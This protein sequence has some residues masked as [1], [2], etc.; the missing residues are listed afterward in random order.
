MCQKLIEKYSCGDDESSTFPCEDFFT[1]G[2]CDKLEDKVID[3][4]S[5]K[6]RECQHLDD[7]LK[8]IA[9]D[10]SLAPEPKR[11]GAEVIDPNRP[12]KYYKEYIKWNKCGHLSH[13]KWTDIERFDDGPEIGFEIEGYGRCHGCAEADPQTLRRMQKNGELEK[14]DPWGFMEAE[15]E[16][17]AGASSIGE[18]MSNEAIALGI[19][20]SAL[21]DLR[22]ENRNA[23]SATDHL[24][25]YKTSIGVAATA[26][27]RAGRRAIGDNDVSRSPSPEFDTGP[28][29]NKG[30]RGHANENYASRYGAHDDDDDDEAVHNDGSSSIYS[31]D[32]ENVVLPAKDA[33]STSRRPLRGASFDDTDSENDSPTSAA[34]H[35]RV[36]KTWGASSPSPS[37]SPPRGGRDRA[38]SD[39]V[40]ISDQE[41]RRL[42]IPPSMILTRASLARFEQ[43]KRDEGKLAMRQNASGDIDEE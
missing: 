19:T 43:R 5:K 26:A 10:A 16:V 34:P 18:Q 21:A 38:D 25:G 35:S 8:R 12:K 23:D 40:E 32:D 24:P 4:K 11:G 39:H 27:V 7:A 14:P 28:G 1:N 29:K 33:K 13:P 6:C 9:E 42:G 17:T 2:D 36:P 22:G 20:D 31:D 3:H 41:R 30:R 15:P 37:P